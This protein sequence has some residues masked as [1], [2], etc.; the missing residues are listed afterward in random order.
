M[1]S[2]PASELTR[3]HLYA[4]VW[5]TPVQR[6]AEGFAISDVALAKLYWNR[7]LVVEVRTDL[8]HGGLP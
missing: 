2:G 5:S 1:E 7:Y 6:A 3:E 4:L 8:P